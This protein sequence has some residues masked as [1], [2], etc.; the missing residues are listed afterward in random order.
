MSSRTSRDPAA[1]ERWMAFYRV[2]RPLQVPCEYVKADA[3]GD[4]GSARVEK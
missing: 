1:I 2:R 4:E 3:Q